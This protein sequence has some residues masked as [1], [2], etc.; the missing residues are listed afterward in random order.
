MTDLNSSS[1]ELGKRIAALNAV[2]SRVTMDAEWLREEA[3][4]LR[5]RHAKI[6]LG[7]RKPLWFLMR[8]RHEQLPICVV[9]PSE[10]RYVSVLAATGLIE[11]QMGAFPASGRYAAPTLATVTRITEYGRAEIARIGEL[12]KPI[13][14]SVQLAR[15]PRLL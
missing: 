11:A 12:P 1:G 2:L 5:A 6:R 8:L 14:S 4:R 9:E 10:I 13:P 15:G 7:N 3:Q